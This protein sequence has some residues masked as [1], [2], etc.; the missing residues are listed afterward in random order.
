MTRTRE[1]VVTWARVQSQRKT[2]GW[3]GMCLKFSRMAGGAAGGVRNANEA[4]ARA[5][6]RHT[7]G[8]PPRGTFVFWAGG[9]HGHV[10]VSSGDGDHYTS[11]LPVR[12]QV[13][14][15]QIADVER[16]WGYRLRGWTEDING[17]RPLD[18][19]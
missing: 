11:D 7:K 13:R 19:D 3:R 16:V 17:V 8:T 18:V 15:G 9:K 6:Y 12:D 10:S 14:W 4:W 2:T 5:E 1:Q